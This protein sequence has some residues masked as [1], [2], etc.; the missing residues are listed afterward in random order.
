M[1]L[2]PFAFPSDTTFRFLLF[3][4][5]IVGV[6][7]LAFEWVYGVLFTDPAAVGRALLACRL[8]LDHVPTDAE[9]AANNACLAA[10]NAP[11]LR[12]VVIAV[13]VLL[14]GGAM[15]YGIAVTR[16]R[17]RYPPFEREASP[18]LADSFASLA[19]ELDV[20]PAPGLRWQPLDRRALGLAL[21]PPG[22]RELAFTGG[23]V[24]LWIRDRP[25][26]RAIVL[27][28]LA[29]LR[30]GDVD[31]SYYAIGLW[32]AFLVLAMV[33]FVLTLLRSLPSDPAT[34]AS[35]G[36][37]F[38]VLVPLVYVI[39]SAIL[40]AREHDADVRASTREPEIRRVLATAASKEPSHSKLRRLVAWHPSTPHRV[41]VIDDPS[42]LLRL[43][44]LD[45]FGIG[46]V[47][48]IAYEEVARNLGFVGLNAIAT[49]GLASLAFG[50]LVGI[51]VALGVW[52]QT[53]AFLATGRSAV[54]VVPLGLAL[55]AGLLVGQRLAF[56]SALVDDAVLLRLDPAA[57][58]VGLTILM[59]FGAILFAAW[60]VTTSRLW[61][62]VATR[63]GSPARAS[64][65]V[66][67]GA[68]ALLFI[69]IAVFENVVASREVVELGLALPNDLHAAVQSLIPLVGPEWLWRLVLGTEVRV[70]IDEPLVLVFFLLLVLIPW[71]AAPFYARIPPEPAATWGGLD[72]TDAP[73][74]IERPELRSR[75]ATVVGLAATI[76]VASTTVALY[77]G[78]HAAVDPVTRDRDEFLIAFYFWLV[79]ITLF[80]QLVA[81]IAAALGARSF[82]TL[83]GVL[84]AFVTGLGGVVVVGLTQASQGCVPGMSVVVGRDCGRPPVIGYLA[85]FW[86]P[87]MTVGI[88]GAAIAAAVTAAV[89]FVIVGRRGHRP[90]RPTFLPPSPPSPPRWLPPTP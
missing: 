72:A 56:T 64:L 58:H 57:F 26:F 83:H 36:W 16:A 20:D 69:A 14:V 59:G 80:W 10:V 52:R 23:L 49:R 65:P 33:P 55:L 29:H 1:R 61:L 81:A 86:A 51:I 85:D 44:L 4:A 24:P 68:A 63:L 41:D 25:A 7:L 71:A 30:N 50:P 47:G 87:V 42:P 74:T 37:R 21:G 60:L 38:L 17:G 40:R 5:A 34:V 54:R 88:V 19:Q 46:I 15:A 43:G 90:T 9:I 27:H 73:P 39:R 53:F 32:R 6:S 78:M 79:C 13:S 84:A 82:G 28:E 22:N 75:W 2:N 12:G 3:I 62:P 45:A 67:V 8:P 31:L 11:L 48:S 35:F 70:F 77:F 18:A 66:A 89:R 76:G